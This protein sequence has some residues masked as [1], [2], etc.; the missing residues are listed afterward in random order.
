MKGEG[1]TIEPY[2]KTCAALEARIKHNALETAFV[3]Q[4]K[5]KAGLYLALRSV[6]FRSVLGFTNT[7]Q[8]TIFWSKVGPRVANRYQFVQ[9]SFLH[10]HT[11]YI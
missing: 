7:R 2:G 3:I 5:K 8:N 4:I 1:S 10:I 9:T 6:P 11:I